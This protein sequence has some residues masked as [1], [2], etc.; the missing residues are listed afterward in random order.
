MCPKIFTRDNFSACETTASWKA[1]WNANGPERTFWG[2]TLWMFLTILM[3]LWVICFRYVYFLNAPILS[4]EQIYSK[5]SHPKEWQSCFTLFEM[6]TSSRSP[7][8]PR[9]NPNFTKP[10]LSC[11]PEHRPNPKTRSPYIA[12]LSLV[13]GRSRANVNRPRS[14]SSRP[15]VFLEAH[16][17]YRSGGE[18]RPSQ[19]KRQEVEEL[20]RPR[21]HNEAARFDRRSRIKKCILIWRF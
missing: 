8:F 7:N 21:D 6:P 1:T 2:R 17:D 12:P 18:V 19:R 13:P 15:T 5:R 14:L 20:E 9:H 4:K 3:L 16:P 11:T 10:P